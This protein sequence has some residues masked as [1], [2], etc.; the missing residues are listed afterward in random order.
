MIFR[1]RRERDEALALLDFANH[2]IDVM[3]QAVAEVNAQLTIEKRQTLFAM[4][5]VYSLMDLIATSELVDEDDALKIEEA[6]E[7][8]SHLIALREERDG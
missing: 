3:N 4:R 7:A 2:T 6:R 1:L 8:I 5:S